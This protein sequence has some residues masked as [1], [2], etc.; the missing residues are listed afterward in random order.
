M[1]FAGQLKKLGMFD[2]I[3]DGRGGAPGCTWTMRR[4]E[5]P[6]FTLYDLADRL[7]VRGWQVPAYPMPANRGDLIVQRVLTRLGVS[8]DLAGL[9]FEDLQQAIKHLIKNPPSKSLTRQSAG[10]YHHS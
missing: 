5:D 7:R 10:G 2:L 9:L 4:G 6:G 3:Y 8:R 1:W